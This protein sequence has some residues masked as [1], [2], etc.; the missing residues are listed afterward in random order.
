MNAQTLGRFTVGIAIIGLAASVLGGVAGLLLIREFNA[1]LGRSLDLTVEALTA[2]DDSLGVA[3]DTLVLVDEGLANTQETSGEVVAALGT[4]AE[5][6]DSTADLTEDELAPSITAVERSLPNLVTVASAVDTALSALS[7]LPVGVSYDPEE[8]L[9]ESLRDIESN[10]AGTGAQLVEQSSLIRDASG[11][12]ETVAT[13]AAVIADDLTALDAGIADAR[14]LVSD[15][16]ATASR[17]RVLIEDTRDD[18]ATRSAI[19][20]ALV[21]LLALAVGAGQIPLL[22]AGR[23]LVRHADRIDEILRAPAESDP[24]PAPPTGGS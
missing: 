17:T 20:A 11:Q 3:A 9:G 18:L 7:R 2:V 5:L 13:G 4:G 23:Q 14:T 22:W 24:A 19:A 16:A 21:V 1:S 10:L 15:Y 8:S 6:L 12:L